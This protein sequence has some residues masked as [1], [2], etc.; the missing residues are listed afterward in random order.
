MKKII[1]LFTLLIFM[2]SC[3]NNKTEIQANNTNENI[4]EVQ[5]EN[6][7]KAE[8]IE[9]VLFHATQRCFS[10]NMM[11]ELTKK[12]LMENFRDD[13]ESGK[14]TFK[15][16]NAEDPINNEIVTKYGATGLSIF[17]NSIIDGKD[18]ISEEQNL[19]RYIQNDIQFKEYLTEKLKSL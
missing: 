3:G 6:I 14:I 10:C 7:Q 18:N 13:F 4:T 5:A 8:K 15:E 12:T 1:I 2:T 17:I 11:E 19:W 9:I 16:I